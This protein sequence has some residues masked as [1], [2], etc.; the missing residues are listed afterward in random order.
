MANE[1]VKYNNE[2]NELEMERWTK[3]EMNLFFSLLF[4][5]KEKDELITV[6]ERELR[7]LSKIKTKDTRRFQQ[8]VHSLSQK[9]QSLSFWKETDAISPFS[10][11]QVRKSTVQSVFETVDV[12]NENGNVQGITIG[13][14]QEFGY[15]FKELS[16]KLHDV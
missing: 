9:L 13:A 12:Y 14:N 4:K 8:S 3:D 2:L 5:I 10:G 6:S 1:T 7:E 15:F 11:K 16:K